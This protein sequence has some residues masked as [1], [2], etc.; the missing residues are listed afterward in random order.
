M[1]LEAEESGVER[2]W[3]TLMVKT[4]RSYKN[5]LYMQGDLLEFG[6]CCKHQPAQSSLV[7]GSATQSNMYPP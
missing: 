5:E 7:L 6:K 1:T 2:V 4:S 3:L